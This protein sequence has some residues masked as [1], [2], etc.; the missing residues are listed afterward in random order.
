MGWSMGSNPSGEDGALG[1]KEARENLGAPDPVGSKWGFLLWPLL[2]P[3]IFVGASTVPFHAGP[4]TCYL[5]G[6]SFQA[7]AELGPWDRSE[8][9]RARAG[10]RP[11]KGRVPEGEGPS[12]LPLPHRVRISPS[13]WKPWRERQVRVARGGCSQPPLSLAALAAPNSA[14]PASSLSQVD[15]S[16][17]PR[18]E[19]PP[20]TPRRSCPP[21][22]HCHLSWYVNQPEQ[23]KSGGV[24]QRV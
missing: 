3:F 16:A 2:P 12:A 15:P 18:S 1:G 8:E 17:T 20:K 23:W 22:P 9:P 19:S 13:C 11:L 14:S 21:P 6:H 24:G 5:Q 7:S 4:R 10:R